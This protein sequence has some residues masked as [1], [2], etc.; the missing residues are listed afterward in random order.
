MKRFKKYTESYRSIDT[1]I[2]GKRALYVG[3]HVDD[4]TVALH[5]IT[6]KKKLKTITSDEIEKVL[7]KFKN[8]YQ[9]V[10]GAIQP[11]NVDAIRLALDCNFRH[12]TDGD[13]SHHIYGREL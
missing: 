1:L 11:H 10:L 3:E 8:K 2:F 5:I 13:E 12:L 9:F 4:K 7:E 6:T